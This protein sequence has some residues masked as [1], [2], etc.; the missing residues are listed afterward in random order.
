MSN[1]EFYT[2]THVYFGR[3]TQRQVGDLVRAQGCKKV[4][5]HF[6]GQS[7]RRSGLL[8]Q[9]EA[10]LDAAGVAHV[11]LGGVVPNPRL[12]LVREGI[13]L[14]RRERIGFVLA[15]GGGSVIDSA[16]AIAMGAPHKGDVWK[17]FAEGTPVE[18]ALK[19]GT[20]LTI[21]AAGSESS[22]NTV[23]T[24]EEEGLK[25]GYGAQVLRP[26]FSI[27][28]PELCL[29]LPPEQLANGV[30]DMMSHIFERYF[31]NTPHV[32]LTDALCEATLRTIM[33]H[34]RRLRASP[35]DADAWA[36]IVF[37]GY[38]AHKGLLGLGRQQDW[39]C[40]GMEH[41]LS[42]LY[43]VAH[44]AGL[45][46]LT[47]AWMEYV[48]RDNVPLFVQFAVNVMGVEG[49]FREPEAVAQEGIRRLRG[50]YKEMGLPSTLE[51]LGIGA[52]KLELMAK[53]A[54]KIAFGAQRPLG[55]LR[56][57]GW[58]DVLAIYRVC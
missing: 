57:L 55:G 51:G 14:C 20:V 46:V 30:S 36:Q 24:N 39:A 12:S 44:G 43:D 35:Q 50:F 17:L 1:F 27:L 26:V 8:D 54:T 2:P 37:S 15:V 19:V 56:K 11:Q 38:V 34:A 47:P 25:L 4:L 33:K 21:P 29:T 48:F 28:D 16:K 23:I 41:E 9:I 45:A 13:A 40:H 52:D 31:S 5:I 18:Q 53:K 6:G 58:Q 32:D 49:G 22:P 3:D 10:S 7:A 42:A